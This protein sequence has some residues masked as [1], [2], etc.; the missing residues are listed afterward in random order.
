MNELTPDEKREKEDDALKFGYA[1]LYGERGHFNDSIKNCS[2]PESAYFLGLEKELLDLPNSLSLFNLLNDIPEEHRERIGG[3]W[4]QLTKHGNDLYLA[5]EVLKSKWENP[6]QDM[7]DPVAHCVSKSAHSANVVIQDKFLK[8]FTAIASRPDRLQNPKKRTELLIWKTEEKNAREGLHKV[9][10]KYL[11]AL[12]AYYEMLLE[13]HGD[14]YVL[15]KEH[16]EREEIINKNNRLRVIDCFH[17]ASG[18]TKAAHHGQ[19]KKRLRK[20]EAGPYVAHEMRTAL[21][22]IVDVLPYSPKVITLTILCAIHDVTED[23]NYSIDEIV[24]GLVRELVDHCDSSLIQVVEPGFPEKHETKARNERRRKNKPEDEERVQSNIRDVFRK[25]IL[26]LI[27]TTRRSTLKQGLR[28]L[29]NKTQLRD[30]EKETVYE[31]NIAGREATKDAL[32]LQFPHARMPQI[33]QSI[34]FHDFPTDYDKGKMTK[35][36]IRLNAIT[37]KSNSTKQAALIT[38]IE[39]RA[40]NIASQENMPVYFQLRNL[41][42]LLKM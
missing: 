39:D 34:T 23:T 26:N 22:A 25:K 14:K 6:P 27:T 8:G 4:K 2:T 15:P 29:S 37:A 20:G 40:D 28:V 16:P 12:K 24:D 21:A 31:Q 33:P 7:H 17:Q 10:K 30:V 18:A 35:F 11:T 36:L 19:G 13:H 42:V 41:T 3:I 32:G 38:K 9:F 1:T 5:E